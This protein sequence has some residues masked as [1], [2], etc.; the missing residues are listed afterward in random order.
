MNEINLVNIIKD[1]LKTK[2]NIVLILLYI[3]TSM[4][5]YV[6]TILLPSSIIDNL[7]YYK[8]ILYIVLFIFLFT[9]NYYSVS[10]IQHRL[11]IYILEELLNGLII[12]RS[13]SNY[14][15]NTKPSVLTDISNFSREL[16]TIIEKTSLIIPTIFIIYSI[17]NFIKK[18]LGYNFIFYYMF[19][20]LLCVLISSKLWTY[21]IKYSYS[22]I[23]LRNKLI[24]YNNDIHN[25]MDSII[26]FNNYENEISNVNNLIN[27]YAF[28]FYKSLESR[29]I[30]SIGNLLIFS[31]FLIFVIYISKNNLER[32][33]LNK[34]IIIN[35]SFILLLSNLLSSFAIIFYFSGKL[36]GSISNINNYL[37]LKKRNIISK[38][39]NYTDALNINNLEYKYP[40]NSYKIKINH[41]EF[42][43]NKI[44][45]LKGKIGCGKSTLLKLIFGI[46]ELNKGDIL[47]KNNSIHNNY[48]DWRKN[49]H[50]LSQHP[51]LFQ[52]DIIENISYPNKKIS[53]NLLNLVKEMNLENTLNNI[54]NNKNSNLSGGQKQIISLIRLI[55]NKKNIILLDEPT[56]SLD[57]YHRNC[58]YK[59]IK[60]MK[61]ENI[62]TIIATHDSKLFELADNIICINNGRII[63][64]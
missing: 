41:L 49:I 12:E 47:Y 2:I 61:G 11:Q 36:Q 39:K 53:S 57:E 45:V 55:N 64:T 52:R 50:Y 56:S 38:S 31:I 62:T 14:K 46:L 5:S 3:L 29:F 6:I 4:Y 34:F 32:K 18:N 24:D 25:N 51:N 23:I 9:I 26:T 28:E 15:N 17:F 40:N 30:F 60:Y 21:I 7:S 19:A 22:Y 63:S 43:N 8:I 20:I 59:I 1:F 33:I 10:H 48:I 27:N 58:V 16:S 35:S 44:T 13:T 54:I 42:K 37:S